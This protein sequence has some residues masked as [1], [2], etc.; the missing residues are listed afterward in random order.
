MPQPD[1]ERTTSK[2]LAADGRH[3]VVVEKWL[4]R[5]VSP[6]RRRSKN[7]RLKLNPNEIEY[8]RQRAERQSA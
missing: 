4:D 6:P 3:L 5:Q 7:Y 1:V 8:Y 2:R